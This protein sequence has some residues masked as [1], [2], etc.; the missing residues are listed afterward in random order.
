[1]GMRNGVSLSEMRSSARRSIYVSPAERNLAGMLHDDEAAKHLER[2]G[3]YAFP[4]DIGD[5]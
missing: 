5:T 3:L 4:A 1:M 2:P